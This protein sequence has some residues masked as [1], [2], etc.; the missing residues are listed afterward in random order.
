MGKTY[1]T[2]MRTSVCS[3]DN[4]VEEYVNIFSGEEALKHNW[5]ATDGSRVWVV[6]PK[7][8]FSH[9]F[10]WGFDNDSEAIAFYEA[11]TT[12]ELG[13]EVHAL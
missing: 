8:E 6:P 12:K 9:T 7:D 5:I 4:R 3:L 10:V 2:M 13:M 1:V 11:L